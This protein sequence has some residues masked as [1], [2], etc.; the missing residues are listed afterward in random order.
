MIFHSYVS[1]PEGMP[2]DASRACCI[3]DMDRTYMYIRLYIYR[4]SGQ[5]HDKVS[6][7]I[8]HLPK[9]SIYHEREA[10][11][12]PKRPI[13]LPICGGKYEILHGAAVLKLHG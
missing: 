3:V 7:S 1:L 2:Y 11:V 10:M 9:L 8:L 6:T 5:G 4:C 13:K 12:V